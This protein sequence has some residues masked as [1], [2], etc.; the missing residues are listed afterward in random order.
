MRKHR[1]LACAA[2]LGG[3]HSRALPVALRRPTPN[4]WR[5]RRHGRTGCA[6][7]S[8][9]S[10]PSRT[11]T[12]SRACR[13]GRP[14]RRATRRRGTTWS[15]RW[16]PPAT[17][18]RA[19]VR[20][21]HLLRGGPGR[22]RAV[23][24][25]PDSSTSATTARTASGTPP[26]SPATATSRRRPSSVDFTEPTATAEHLELRLRGRPTS[27]GASPA[28]SSLLQR[29]TCDFGLK[30]ENA[31]AAGAVGAVIFNEG[32]IGAADR[33]DV[34]IPTLAGYDATHPGRR[35]RLRDRPRAGRPRRGRPGHAARQGRRL[36]QPGRPD[37]Q[38][39]RRD[40]RRPQP[41]APWSSAAHLDSVY[42]G[43]GI[44]DDG[45]GV[46]D[47]ARDRRADEALGSRPRNKVR[48]IFFSGEE[49]GLLGS[50]YYV[51]QLTKKQIHDISV[52]LDYDMLAS[53]QL[54]PLH[55]RRQ[56]RRAG[57][58]R[59]ERLR[60]DRAGVQG[61]WD[62][63]GLAYETIPFDGR[64]DYDAFTSSASRP[65]ASSP[66]PRA[67]RRPARSRCTAARPGWRS[68]RATTSSATPWPTS[69]SR[70]L[71]AQGRRRPRD[72]ARSPRRRPRSTAPTRGRPAPRRRGT[73]RAT[74]RSVAVANR[75]VPDA[76][77]AFRP[78]VAV[79]LPRLWHGPRVT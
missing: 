41:T 56:R 77:A 35:H 6:S 76:P 78:G 53:R 8:R 27:P 45:S 72:R 79:A 54:R 47:D 9:R 40:A 57:L 55:L 62:S 66:A 22:V 18:S 37:Q 20:G 33:N 12:S 29:G 60:R 75:V 42:E 17:T 3:S 11:R 69:T 39:D 23:V 44:N 14:G 71:G 2:V 5:G 13:P 1:P 24:A 73:G 38:R 43:P 16:R 61:L 36:R 67:S 52:M 58:R 26:T 28:R 21:R 63:Q 64:S 65:A 31:Q 34:L 10:R 30:V 15:R 4:R 50:D 74:S 59:P 68:T 46:G 7:I 32:T 19:A 70:A 48:F 51:S 49:Q 25:E